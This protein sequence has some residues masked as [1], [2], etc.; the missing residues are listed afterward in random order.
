MAGFTTESF[1]SIQSLRNTDAQCK[2]NGWRERKLWIDL[3]LSVVK[4]VIS[5][6]TEWSGENR[7]LCPQLI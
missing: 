1:Q 6:R 7:A 3:K 4:P 2:S 5:V